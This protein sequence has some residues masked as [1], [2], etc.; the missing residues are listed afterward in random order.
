MCRSVD[1]DVFF[2]LPLKNRSDTIL[3][4]IVSFENHFCSM[5]DDDDSLAF[6]RVNVCDGESD[7]DTED[8]LP[9]PSSDH[10]SL[11]STTTSLPSS[12]PSPDD[13][14]LDFASVRLEDELWKQ[15]L[16]DT[17]STLASLPKKHYKRSKIP[18]IGPKESSL[19][20]YYIS[21]TAIDYLNIFAKEKE[22]G[23]GWKKVPVNKTDGKNNI[24]NTILAIRKI[25]SNGVYQLDQGVILGM[26]ANQW[27]GENCGS[28]PAMH[29]NDRIRVYGLVMSLDIH[30]DIFQRL[31]K[32][33]GNRTHL[34]D[35]AFSLPK[36][37]QTIAFAFNNDKIVVN[38]PNEAC[39]VG[40]IQNVDPN[41]MARI[42]IT[43]DCEFIYFVY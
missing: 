32:G 1:S 43:R 25:D 8:N 31:A 23:R 12:F 33:V 19:Y 38:L 14:T 42:R 24:I 15:R 36:I 4:T 18:A 39:D 34:D 13:S 28:D 35:P 17:G 5:S 37:Y 10:A 26:L 29:H 20:Y 16:Q 9:P 40:G 6:V 30:R 11:P 22:L 27:G 21:Q 2:C 7:T 41:D 3:G